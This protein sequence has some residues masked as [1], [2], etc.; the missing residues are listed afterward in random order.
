MFATRLIEAGELLMIG[1]EPLVLVRCFGD[2]DDP[3]EC[4]ACDFC[5]APLSHETSS[6]ARCGTRFCSEGCQHEA[7]RQYHGSICGGAKGVA[8]REFVAHA[9]RHS[10]EYYLMAMKSVGKAAA[11]LAEGAGAF[12]EVWAPWRSLVGAPWWETLDADD[13]YSQ[14]GEDEYV[15]AERDAAEAAAEEMEEGALAAV[16]EDD[17]EEGAAAA[18][19]YVEEAREDGKGGGH[20]QGAVASFVVNTVPGGGGA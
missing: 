13:T 8:F 9:E 15:L 16:A 18:R 5:L 3:Q 19:V 12:D 11:R 6:C 14:D 20:G 4:A 1:Q 7:Q 2:E 17:E 10:N